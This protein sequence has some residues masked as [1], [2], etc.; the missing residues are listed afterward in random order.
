MGVAVLASKKAI[1]KVVEELTKRV[2]EWLDERYKRRK[3]AG[4]AEV[5]LYGPDGQ[6]IN[7][8]AI[9]YDGR[10]RNR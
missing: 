2:F 8:Q 10:L 5:T 3:E 9:V 4:L 6:Q 1:E 7:R